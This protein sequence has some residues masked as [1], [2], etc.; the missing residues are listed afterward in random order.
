MEN[1][2]YDNQVKKILVT[3]ASGFLGSRICWYLEQKLNRAYVPIFKEKNQSF[4]INESVHKEKG[5]FFDVYA[6]SHKEMDIT[7]IDNVE[8]YIEKVK[9]EIVIHCAAISDTGYTEEHKEESFR[10]NVTGTENLAKVTGK[11]GI[12]FIFMSSDQIYNGKTIEGK[13]YSRS[14]DA[15]VEEK[16]D[17]PVNEYGRQKKEAEN[18]SLKANPD[19]IAL[20]LTW[21]YDLAREGMKTNRNLLTNLVEADRISAVLRFAR[22]EYRGI[23]NVW[24]VVS[25]LE[26][27]FEIPPGVYNYG[28]ENDQATIEIAK[29]AVEV[30]ELSKDIVGEDLERYAT[31]PRNLTVC[32]DRLK[33]VGI[34]FKSTIDGLYE[35]LL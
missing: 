26:K 24:E 6:P 10:I 20:R 14:R 31:R 3:G 8:K 21:M 4:G 22:Y 30:L 9:P 34:E 17:C 12:R 16:D 11:R 28:S 13:T 33:S 23:T 29:R 2:R 19:T 5:Q 18:R 27:V 7:D 25:N 1:E 15:C 35:F 32:N